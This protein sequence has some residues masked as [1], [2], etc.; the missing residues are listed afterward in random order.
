MIPVVAVALV[1]PDGRV[2]M[3]R[4]RLGGA[5]GGLWEF[6]GGKV[7]AAESADQALIREAAE[8]LG[9]TLTAADLSALT[10]ATRPGDPYGVLLYLCRHWCGTP[11]CLDGEEIAW[12]AP[13]ALL[14]LAMPPLDVPLAEAVKEVLEKT[15]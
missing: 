1:A 6:P 12:I 8:E 13:D 15:I 7:E 2:L 14:Q 10:F 4:R 9:I 5:H 3:Q 11:A